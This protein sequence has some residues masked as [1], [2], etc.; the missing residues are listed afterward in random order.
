MPSYK[1][2]EFLLYTVLQYNTIQYNTIQ[3]QY[4]VNMLM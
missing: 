1:F 4:S 2:G 3:I